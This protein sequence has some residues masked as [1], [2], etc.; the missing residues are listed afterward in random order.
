MPGS[1]DQYRVGLL[2]FYHHPGL[3]AIYLRGRLAWGVV[4]RILAILA[5]LIALSIAGCFHHQQT[6]STPIELPPLK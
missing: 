1:G 6:M 4:M 5:A 2:Q 3:S